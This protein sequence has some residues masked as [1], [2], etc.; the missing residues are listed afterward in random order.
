MDNS[1]PGVSDLFTLNQFEFIESDDFI[2]GQELENCLRIDELD[3]SEEC[4]RLFNLGF[5]YADVAD[6]LLDLETSL[7]SRQNNY[8]HEIDSNPQNLSDLEWEQESVSSQTNLSDSVG[9]DAI[10][11]C[12]YSQSSSPESE[13]KHWKDFLNCHTKW[14]N[15]TSSE[16]ASVIWGLAQYLIQLGPR[17]S[18]DVMKILNPDIKLSQINAFTF[19]D[20]SLFSDTKF[21]LIQNYLKNRR[22]SSVSSNNVHKTSQKKKSQKRKMSKI[23]D[24]VTK[25][26]EQAVKEKKSGLFKKEIVISLSTHESTDEDID[27]DIIG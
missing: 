23:V 14:S 22:P 26:V 19:L 5:D 7:S 18:G 27:I 25:K 1:L 16:Q 9:F 12:D 21:Q 17:E 6:N 4:D 2:E 11:V 3:Y 15:L 20:S 24:S 8:F 10:D 13:S